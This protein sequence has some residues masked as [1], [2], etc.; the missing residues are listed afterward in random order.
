[1]HSTKRLSLKWVA[2]SQAAPLYNAGGTSSSNPTSPAIDADLSSRHTESSTPAFSG[3]AGA[4]N[5]SCNLEL[6]PL[7]KRHA[8]RQGGNYR[9]VVLW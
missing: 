3:P 4:G 6:I 7:S 5:E 9:I 2:S 8:H 1:M